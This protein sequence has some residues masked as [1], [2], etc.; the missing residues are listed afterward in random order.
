MMTAFTTPEQITAANKATVDSFIGLANVFLAGAERMTSATLAATRE[1][2]EDAMAH[3]KAVMA[4]KDPQEF[5][6][7]QNAYGQPVA[8]KALAYSRSLYEIASEAQGQVSKAFEAQ[9]ADM[10]HNVTVYLDKAVKSAPPGSEVVVNAF[11]TM[12]ATANTTYD[13][14]VKA[15]KQV[16]EITE[17]NVN[18]AHSAAVKAAGTPKKKAA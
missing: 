16:V 17:A 10:N 14:V 7:L 12:V 4:A 5:L 3:T 6:A 18:A 8:E 9:A 2:W 11:K 1:S 13:S 15:S